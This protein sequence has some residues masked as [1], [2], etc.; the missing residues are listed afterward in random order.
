VLGSLFDFSILKYPFVPLWQWAV[1]HRRI[2]E[3]WHCIWMVSTV[4]KCWLK[5]FYYFFCSL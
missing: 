4:R 1:T 5:W 3:L 2:P